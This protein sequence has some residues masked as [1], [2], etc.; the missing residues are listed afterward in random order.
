M[1]KTGLLNSLAICL[2]LTACAPTRQFNTPYKAPTGGK[3]AKLQMRSPALPG[4]GFLLTFENPRT[5]SDPRLISSSRLTGGQF[6]DGT[7]LD[8]N[9]PSTLWFRYISAS[10]R[11]CNVIM[12]F[13]PEGDK[14]YVAFAMASE[15]S[16][17]LSLQDISDPA[18]PRPVRRYVQRNIAPNAISSGDFCL[19]AGTLDADLTK[20]RHPNLSGLKMED[21]KDLL[22]PAPAGAKP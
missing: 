13:T 17:G 22:P 6:R 2:A 9:Q 8:A 15:T 4:S 19:G 3:L 10:N 16:C 11:N 21:L 7:A 20:T 12:T 18:N 1:H 14:N 5:C